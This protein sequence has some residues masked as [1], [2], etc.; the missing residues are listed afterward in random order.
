MTL[1]APGHHITQRLG[2]LA[3][4]L[5]AP[6]SAAAHFF[7]PPEFRPKD[8]AY[9][10]ASEI[11][12]APET[13]SPKDTVFSLSDDVLFLRSG[14]DSTDIDGKT[15]FQTYI[16]TAKPP[17][18]CIA[19]AHTRGLPMFGS[20]MRTKASAGSETIL[21]R[22]PGGKI[23]VTPAGEILERPDTAPDP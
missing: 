15:Y 13:R 14:S 9:A 2:L 5:S 6:F 11:C 23:E 21:L 22:I 18:R 7:G 3:V 4:L 17:A 16:L 10:L 1:G 20:V 8:A 19:K 12:D